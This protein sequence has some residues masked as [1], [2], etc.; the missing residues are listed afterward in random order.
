MDELTMGRLRSERLPA[1]PMT[2]RV[3]IYDAA[4]CVLT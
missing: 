1:T 3:H 2:A 4:R